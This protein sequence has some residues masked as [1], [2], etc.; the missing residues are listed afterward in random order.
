MNND[1]DIL[2]FLLIYLATYYFKLLY[3]VLRVKNITSYDY[4]MVFYIFI[5]FSND[6]ILIGNIYIYIYIYIVLA[7]FTFDNIV[8]I[9]E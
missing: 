7:P 1:D 4:V 3:F 6:L 5:L 2:F 9:V 8:N